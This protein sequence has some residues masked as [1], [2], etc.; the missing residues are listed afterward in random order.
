MHAD[1]WF[2][3][4]HHATLAV[5]CICLLNAEQTFLP[6]VQWMMAPVVLIVA[7]AW[8]M[9]GRW[10]LP[11][12]AAN[13]LGIAL[14][15]G[16]SLLLRHL[17]QDP[18]SWLQTARMPAGIVPLLGP[19]LIGLLLVRLF[20]PR[21]AADFW[22]LQGFG[23]L[24]V[25]L[26]CVIGTGVELGLLLPLYL[27]CALGCLVEHFLV[28]GL[29]KSSTPADLVGLPHRPSSPPTRRWAA[30]TGGL[31][32]GVF[33]L[34][35]VP[36]VGTPAVLLFLV[37]PRPEVTEW[38]R[39][40]G[41]YSG[42][43]PTVF[44]QT[45][46]LSGID[47]NA[48]GWVELSS[49]PAFFVDAEDS[50]SQ[51]VLDLPTEQR[52]RFRVLDIYDK[53]QWSFLRPGPSSI[54]RDYQ[55]PLSN[56]GP[57]QVTLQFDVKVH[58]A[59]GLFLADPIRLP[60]SMDETPVAMDHPKTLNARFLEDYGTLLPRTP[61]DWQRYLYRQVY[62]PDRSN[63][64]ADVPPLR[65]R[66]NPSYISEIL[67]KNPLPPLTDWTVKLLRRLAEDPRYRLARAL[68]T[69]APDGS[70]RG[71]VLDPDDWERVAR[72]LT[73]YLA[74]GGEYGYSSELRRQD[75]DLDPTLDFLWNIKQGTCDRYA[76][77]LTLMLRS[78]GI[79]GRVVKGYRGLEREGAGRYVVLQNQAHSWVEA[80][81]PLRNDPEA[82]GWVTLDPTPIL[83]GPGGNAFSL[84]RL[85]D[86]GQRSSQFFWEE[87]ILGYNSASREDLLQRMLP[88]WQALATVAG[89]IVAVAV[90]WYL[91]RRRQWRKARRAAARRSA[92]RFYTRLLALLQRHLGLAPAL[93]QTPRDFA[94]Q[95]EEALGSAG[96]AATIPGEIVERFYRARFGARPL[97][98][99]EAAS[100]DRLL[101]ALASALERP[102]AAPSAAVGA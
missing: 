19:L 28:G 75:L 15:A 36:L 78:V 98:E 40:S 14:L 11:V 4:L 80:I 29:G 8:R 101:A 3:L 72:A 30:P 82:L 41:T 66:I 13:V 102:G 44:K 65:C 33:L 87:L 94:R 67:F 96:P 32:L 69:P 83:D 64:R 23:A 25:S 18:N 97:T 26:A 86:R 92:D 49:D 16:F 70:T 59:G 90:L 10:R 34:C 35:W 53:G 79:P 51:P 84:A 54:G 5:A 77:A 20:R 38:E 39:P 46:A 71:F 21:V 50:Q 48:T 74:V 52:W 9:E 12:W 43:Q 55:Q 27:A 63:R 88:S 58:D 61:R 73:D 100:M 42:V 56:F 17:L 2:R 60:Q 62:I 31:R 81:V 95:A 47:M 57:D 24:Q 6:G 45:G 22:L 89:S 68:P 76:G 85:L 1:R 7:L 99:E 37:M 91:L 93:A